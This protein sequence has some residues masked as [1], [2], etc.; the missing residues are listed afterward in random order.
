LDNRIP[1]PIVAT[2]TAIL[3]DI[4]VF[5]DFASRHARRSRHGGPNPV[6]TPVCYRYLT[7]RVN[8]MV[9]TQGRQTGSARGEEKMFATK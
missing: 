2:A 5:S 1:T 4:V 3:I 9:S 6:K 8:Q 7:A